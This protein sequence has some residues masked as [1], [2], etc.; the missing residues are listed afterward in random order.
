ML[1]GRAARLFV[2][3]EGVAMTVDF[4]TVSINVPNGTGRRRIFGSTTFPTGV[5]RA[6][7]TLNGF[8]ADFA[9]DDHH[10]NVIEV[11]TDVVNFTGNTVNFVVECQYADKNFDDSY[12]GFVTATVIVDR[13]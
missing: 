11:D 4:R 5:N 3:K 13:D 10:I 12:A 9:D 8:K 7:V 6:A 2:R 1:R